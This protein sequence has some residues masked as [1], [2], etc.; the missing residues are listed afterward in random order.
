MA[1]LFARSQFSI[2]LWIEC[3]VRGSKSVVWCEVCHREP[4]LQAELV[5]RPIVVTAS[6]LKQG[7]THSKARA[8]KTPRDVR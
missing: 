5:L 7:S 8:K 4:S 6:A 3:C 2:V 1:D